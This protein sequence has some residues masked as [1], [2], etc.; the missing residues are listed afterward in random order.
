MTMKN[1]IIIVTM[2][3]GIFI[4]MLD[5][6]VMNIA[7]P[8][9]QTGLNTNLSSLSWALNIYTIMFAIFT[10]PF[11]RIADI[12]GRNKVYVLGLFLFLTGSAI[13]GLSVNI[14][15]LIAGRA[16]QSLG[17][18]IVFPSSMT[19]GIS[20][21]TMDKRTVAIAV[22]GTTQGLAAALGPTIG[23]IVTQFMGWR[24]I[25]L[26]NIPLAIIS[27]VLCFKFLSFTNESKVKTGVDLPGVLT[28]MV[29]LFSLTL[30]LIKGSDWGWTS[31]T[32]I[33]LFSIT[34]ISLIVFVILETRSND[35]MVPLQLFKN[36]Q[37]TG[38][39]LSIMLSGIFLVAIMVIMP[40]FF[41]KI[42]GESELMAALMITPASI[43]IFVI[44]PLS[45]TI[46]PKIGARTLIALGFT[47]I[48]LGYIVLALCNPTHYGQI[49]GALL[50]IGGGF[51]IVVGPIM[52]LG[53]ADFT[54]TMLT[55][56][57]SVLGVLRQVGT[58]LAVAIYVSALTTNIATAKNKTWNSTQRQA[59]TLAIS[60]SA[61]KT[62]L[63]SVHQ[64]LYGN[65]VGTTTKNGQ[66]ISEAKKQQITNQAYE[67]ALAKNDANQAT[68]SEKSAIRA[69]VQQNVNRQVNHENHL[70]AGQVTK[71]KNSI[72]HNL[73][74]A[75]MSLYRLS[76]PATILAI[77]VSLLFKRKRQ[78]AK[79]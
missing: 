72:Q 14:A 39:S 51:G 74:N 6:T 69:K 24:W 73:N 20:S 28:S 22:L 27:L 59:E 35:P 53:A 2:A 33:G 79:P 32:T 55:A 1:K 37:F 18:A 56:S 64:G 46:L 21:V 41:T 42:Q 16:I 52:V 3:V 49:L 47:L 43:M 71:T 77:A 48:A 38:A 68:K 7:L 60:A 25:F 36:R 5:T 40:T 75:F 4:C 26:I 10:I 15:M 65:S 45:S 62:V 67:S 66:Y 13:S 63:K 76:V 31:L 19:I 78:A 61:K 34:V 17:A 9:I 23:G 30:A 11:G 12:V 29:M 70:I 50:L 8:A 54:G 57:Q 44:A 58:V